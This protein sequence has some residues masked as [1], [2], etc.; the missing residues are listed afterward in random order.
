MATRAFFK[1]F[2]PTAALL[3]LVGMLAITVWRTGSAQ[4]ATEGTPFLTP[5][6]SIQELML[7]TVEDIAHDVWSLAYKEG[8]LTNREWRR[9]EGQALSLQ[10]VATLISLGG[11]GEGDAERIASPD[12][13]MW[14]GNLRNVAISLQ[15][16]IGT[17]DKG[18]LFYAGD[19]LANACDG[20]HLIFRPSAQAEGVRHMP[21]YW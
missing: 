20:C 13:Q 14:A 18:A 5:S 8:D 16:S 19:R 15:E 7:S 17:R 21:E 6:I 10:A 11:T 2:K 12:Y 3:A 9:V 4:Q 1:I